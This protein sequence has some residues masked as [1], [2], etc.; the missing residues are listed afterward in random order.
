MKI[1]FIFSKC[2]K[3][4]SCRNSSSSIL[5]KMSLIRHNI[6]INKFDSYILSVPK[7]IA[8]LY[9]ICLSI[10]LQIGHSVF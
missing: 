2:K 9:F 3:M 7:I 6:E 1:S 8:N 10:D 5:K 4:Q